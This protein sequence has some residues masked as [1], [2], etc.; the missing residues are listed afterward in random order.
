M[1]QALVFSLCKHL[2]IVLSLVTYW[3]FWKCRWRFQLY[4][5]ISKLPYWTKYRLKSTGGLEGN[6]SEAMVCCGKRAAP[7]GPGWET[8]WI[9]ST[10]WHISTNW[11]NILRFTR[12]LCL[13]MQNFFILLYSNN[14]RVFLV[15]H[16]KYWEVE[17]YYDCTHCC[18]AKNTP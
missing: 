16:F 9:T 12:T 2:S 5:Q 4:I 18:R 13:C 1:L 6:Q 8:G 7:W 14:Q 11:L 10:G 15:D 3:G 17:I